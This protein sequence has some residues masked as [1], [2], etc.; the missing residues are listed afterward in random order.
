[1]ILYKEKSIYLCL[2]F[3]LSLLMSSCSN[4]QLYKNNIFNPSKNVRKEEK[5]EKVNPSLEANT[6]KKINYLVSL[7]K[8]K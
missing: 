8:F 7:K 1:M 5:L 2:F 4:Q 3:I 6:S